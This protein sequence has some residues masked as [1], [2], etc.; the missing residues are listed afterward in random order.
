MQTI[1]YLIRH[2]KKINKEDIDYSLSN[3]SKQ[4][5]N[6]K[7]P[8]SIE[9]EERAKKLS[10]LEEFAD[11]ESIYSSNYTR[12]IQTAKYLAE[13]RNLRINVD[14]RFNERKHGIF[15]GEINLER[16][17]QEDFKNPDGE[18]PKEVRKRMVEGFEY[19]INNNKGKKIAI[20][21][22][23]AAMTMLL[24]KWCK[25]EHITNDTKK[26]ISYKGKILVDK[27]FNQ[28]EIFKLILDENNDIIN[29]EN[30]EVNW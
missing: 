10:E 5:Q 26:T 18:S 24:T 9:G 16:Y 29:I 23:G 27:I 3:E 12:T 1:V 25:L 4:I 22:H 19:A 21:T 28:P 20:F 15:N 30:I 2:S 8:L 17:Y 11:I 13:K 6:E 7:I 14:E